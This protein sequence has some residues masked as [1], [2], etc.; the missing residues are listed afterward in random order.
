MRPQASRGLSTNAEVLPFHHEAALLGGR[1]N[2]ELERV[3]RFIGLP[4]VMIAAI[5]IR[6]GLALITDNTAH[7]EHIRA[8]KYDLFIDNWRLP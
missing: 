2:A 3:G 7:F 5:A 4:D 8:A 1:I 6:R